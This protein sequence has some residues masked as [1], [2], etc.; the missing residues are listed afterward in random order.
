MLFA[1]RGKLLKKM[2]TRCAISVGNDSF[3]IV[4]EMMVPLTTSERI[5]EV[6]DTVN[7]YIS[8]HKLKD[9]PVL[10]G[11]ITEEDR[12]L[13]EE[14]VKLPGIGPGLALRVLS[15]VTSGELVGAI[16]KGDID[17][18]SKIKGLGR[19]RAERII[20]E[21][22][23]KLPEI[24]EKIVPDISR[25]EIADKAVEALVVLG[26]NSKE[27]RSLVRRVLEEVGDGISLEDLI[28]KALEERKI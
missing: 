5:G 21:L 9:I 12:S 28:R 4:F 22:R 7:L 16:E 8:L 15:G 24:R 18:I 11:F 2:P 26:M 20:F 13:F 6:G 25:I 10:Y 27:A 1:I 14:M 3:S 23:G 19:K 17:K